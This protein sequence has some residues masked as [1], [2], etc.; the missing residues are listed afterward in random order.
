M[1]AQPPKDPRQRRR[2]N[3]PARG[4][5]QASPGVGWQHGPIPAPPDG[6]VEASHDAWE[7]WFRAWFA[8]HRHPGDLPGL[9]LMISLFDRVERGGAKAADHSEL[10]LWLDSYGISL[11]GQADRRWQRPPQPLE[12]APGDAPSPYAHLRVVR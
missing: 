8:A 5:W 12:A 2:R 11:K 10:R 9:R 6:L 7:T 3:A 4:E 1:P